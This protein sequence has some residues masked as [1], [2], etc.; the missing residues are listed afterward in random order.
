[1]PSNTIT[2]CAI[3]VLLAGV[4]RFE[5]RKAAE[6]LAAERAQAAFGPDASSDG[7]GKTFEL[8]ANPVAAGSTK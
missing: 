2:F 4:E 5:A 7:L 3:N 1:M 6:K 8:K